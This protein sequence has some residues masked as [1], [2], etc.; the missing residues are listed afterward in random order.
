MR[1]RFTCGLPSGQ[2]VI[3]LAGGARYEGGL[4]QGRPHG[5]GL[6]SAC[7]VLHE[8][9]FVNGQRWGAGVERFDEEA[10]GGARSLKG[11][12]AHD[13]PAAAAVLQT[14]DGC[15][16]TAKWRGG[17]PEGRALLEMP[18]GKNVSRVR[19]RVRVRV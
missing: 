14:G 5:V 8:G 15:R 4:W 17:A 2:G 13:L 6:L 7:G 11:A 3:E 19:V 12:W 18:S 1:G 16:L 10:S 9:G